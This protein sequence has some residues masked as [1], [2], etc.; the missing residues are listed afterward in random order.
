M[1]INFRNLSF[2]AASF[3][4]LYGVSGCNEST[5]L[6]KGLIPPGDFVNGKDT[7]INGVITNNIYKYD[8]LFFN[9][10]NFYEKA[11]GS[12]TTDPVFGKTHAFVFMQVG[13]PSS[14]FT[15]AGTGQ[16]LDSVVLSLAYLGYKG[17]STTTQTY[18]VYRM[19]EQGFR[20]DSNYAYNKPLQYNPGELLGTATVTPLTIRDSVSV[21]GTKETAQLRIKLSN[22]FGNDLLQQK[23]DGAFTND[24]TFRAYLKGFAFVP[25]TT[26][27]ANRNMLFFDM[28][29]AN[30][31]LTVFYKNSVDDSLRATFGF[32]SRSGH[33]NFIARNY[34]GSE[35]SRFINTGNANGDSVLFLQSTPG[36]YTNVLIPGLENFPNA[37]INKAELVITQITVGSG[38]M[39][40]IFTEPAKLSLLQYSG[41]ND[42]LKKVID[43]TVRGDD[44]FGGKKVVVTNFGGVQVSQYSFNIG[45]FLQML[46]KK[47]ETNSGFRLQVARTSY[48]DIDRLKAGGSNLSQYNIKLRIIYTKP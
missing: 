7:T 14:A 37:V 26:S 5:I 47:Q 31:K 44:Y 8:S 48:A 1:K 46:I 12:I 25:D 32:G 3:A 16:T 22:A 35:A 20:I 2:V 10:Y 13:L 38:D 39:N 34:N 19:A 6:G 17:D 9:G 45:T 33:A 42:T 15:F 24:S 11:L 18:R 4:L 41:A 27:G 23:S 21:Y 40:N 36:L 28:S 30:T 43:Q 29:G